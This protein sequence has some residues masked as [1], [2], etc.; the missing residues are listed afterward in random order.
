MGRAGNPVKRWRRIAL[1]STILLPTIVFGSSVAFYLSG[2]VG[3]GA[4]AL[5]GGACGLGGLISAWIASGREKPDEVVLCVV[6]GMLP[7]MGIPLFVC[8]FVYLCGGVVVE[9]GFVYYI[10]V[11]YFITLVVDVGL[12]FRYR[13]PTA[14]KTETG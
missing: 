11:F 6:G 8:F 10:L 3:V 5:A 4:A 14:A 2:W 7:R 9:A 13:P 1:F 12:F